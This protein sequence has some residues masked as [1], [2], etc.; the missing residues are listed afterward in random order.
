[1][2]LEGLDGV[3]VGETTL[4][5][6]RGATGELY[7]RG[8]PAAELS[9]VLTYEG[10]VHLLFQ[11]EL[12]HPE[13]AQSLRTELARHREWPEE[14]LPS[15]ERL[16]RGMTP[17]ETLRT[18]V[19][20]LGVGWTRFPPTQEDLLPFIARAPGGLAR[21]YRAQRGLPPVAPDPSLGHVAN[22]LYQL[23]G[24][25]PADRRVRALE[26]YF[27]LV[28]EHG[29]NASTFAARVTIST[30]SDPASALTAALSTLKGPLHGG[31]PSLVSDMLDRVGTPQAAAQWIADA[32]GRRERLMG[33][34]HRVYR[35]ED[36]RA[37]RLKE[38]AREVA[39]P[40][41][42]A[43][44]EA[45]ERAGLAAL[46]AK[47]PQ[48]PLYLNVEFYA[49]VVLEAAG[50]PPELFT[51]TFGLARLAGYSAH[52]L[53]QARGNRLIRPEVRYAGPGPRPVPVGYSLR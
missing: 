31:A 3:V 25:P 29:M 15:L 24:R 42:F 50:L 49:A 12:P 2:G 1:M 44:A 43:L 51:P 32:L 27:V 28:A 18:L 37:V 13:E 30:Q 8:Y 23:E 47:N 16:P 20:L 45:V 19:S 21:A 10:M 46:R 6:V 35:T 39:S 52:I 41:R 34:G 9:R 53:E 17:M 14:S 7:V 38:I 48:R 11:G 26:S 36:P 5:D 33:F 22:Y 4:S 40:S